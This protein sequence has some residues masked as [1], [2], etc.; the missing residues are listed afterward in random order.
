[1]IEMQEK[2]DEIET[3][4]EGLAID[5]NISLYT[6]DDE[7]LISS[8][9]SMVKESEILDQQLKIQSLT[10]EA[11]V[12]KSIEQYNVQYQRLRDEKVSLRQRLAEIQAIDKSSISQYIAQ[13]KSQITKAAIE[14]AAKIVESRSSVTK[15]DIDRIYLLSLKKQIKT[16]LLNFI[17]TLINKN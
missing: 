9:E 5:Q 8:I 12:K 11:K 1:M 2:F 3:M 14:E 6:L 15:R 10:G 4:V 17:S 13:N 16:Y 7:T